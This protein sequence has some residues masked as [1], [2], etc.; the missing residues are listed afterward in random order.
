M[1]GLPIRERDDLEPNKRAEISTALDSLQSGEPYHFRK[2]FGSPWGS[3]PF[4]KWATI[5]HALERLGW[6][7]MPRSSIWDVAKVDIGVS[8]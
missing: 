6:R 3:E 2:P 5:G 8:R 7:T 4:L 1:T